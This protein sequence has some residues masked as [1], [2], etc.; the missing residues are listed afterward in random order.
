MNK[1]AKVAVAGAVAMVLGSTMSGSLLPG[2]VGAA[3]AEDAKPA[4]TAKPQVSAAAGKDLQEAQKDM[5]AQKWDDMLVV[6]DKVKNNPK[7]ND[8]DEHVMN[9]FY[10]T[11][12]ANKKQLQEATG[13]LEF[14]IASKF[15]PPDEM[16]K[17]VVQAAFLY[18]QLQ[19]YDK[20]IDYGNRAI[21]DGYS[22][23]QVPL[24]VAQSYYLKNDFKN[25]ATFVRGLV[26]DQIKAGTAPT[27][28]ML[29]LGLS[30]AVKLNDEAAESHWLELLV[31]YHPKAEYW[32]NLLDGLLR[33]KMPDR[34]L[35]QVYRLSAEVGAMKSGSDYAEMAQAALD[36]GSPGE[37]V[38]VLTKAFAANAFTD[39][40]EKNRNQHLLDT[41]KK[42]AASDQPT[43]AKAETDAMT[44]A[45]G[46]KLVG[47]GTGYFGYG[48]YDKAA[49]DIAAGLAKGAT[50]DTE[51]ARL[52][53]GIAQ[54]KAGSKDE[55]L[56]T[57]SSV[58]GDAPLQRLAALWALRVK[59]P[60]SAAT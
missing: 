26:D 16:K 39:Q 35:L 34:E 14:L 51:N 54:F 18:Y 5:Q 37:A 8:Y 25:T 57:F 15:T 40:A 58:K 1:V 42:Q 27:D 56:K 53:L 29:Q 49:K 59:A 31:T 30:S 22:N 11:A 6:L 21:K 9:E 20:A 24:V 17:R 47:V 36:A 60:A 52:L 28:E 7:K 19:N 41:A 2:Y 13:P 10:V 32:Q 45:G 4:D 33:T 44:A 55:A 48:E 23:E 43:L 38:A 12:Y 3:A 46:D 50:K